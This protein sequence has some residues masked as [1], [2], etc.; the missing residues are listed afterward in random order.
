[1]QTSLWRIC[2]PETCGEMVMAYSEVILNVKADTKLL[3]ERDF[4]LRDF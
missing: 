1:M 2:E 3:Q 4:D